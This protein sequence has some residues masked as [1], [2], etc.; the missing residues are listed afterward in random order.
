MIVDEM[1]EV[2]LNS[3]TL[4]YYRSISYS[5]P[6]GDKSVMVRSC[7]ILATSHKRIHAVCDYCGEV[8]EIEA[9]RYYAMVN[10]EWCHKACCKGCAPLK[11]KE[12]NLEHY[13]VELPM[14]LPENRQKVKHTLM[15]KYGVDHISKIPSVKEKVKETIRAKYGC[16]YYL[17]S[18]DAKQKRKLTNMQRY[19]VEYISQSDDIQKRIKLSNLQ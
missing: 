14:L 13:G 15:D 3:Q 7:D 6:K 19:G 9:R 5:I 10:N 1:I 11:R 16:D 8:F 2:G 12:A 18:E 4:N 17:S